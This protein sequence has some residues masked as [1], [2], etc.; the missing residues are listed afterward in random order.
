MS[1]DGAG[2]AI[3]AGRTR[4]AVAGFRDPFRPTDRR[5]DTDPERTAGAPARRAGF[6]SL[7][8]TLA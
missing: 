1:F 2:P 4:G 8:D 3:A 5:A 7:N 6:N